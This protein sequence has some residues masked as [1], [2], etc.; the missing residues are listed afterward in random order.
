[1]FLKL[2]QYKHLGNLVQMNECSSITNLF[3]YNLKNCHRNVD[4]EKLH[5]LQVQ[6][7]KLQRQ[8]TLNSN[9]YA[10]SIYLVLYKYQYFLQE[11]ARLSSL[12]NSISLVVFILK[13]LNFKTC[14]LTFYPPKSGELSKNR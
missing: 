11:I 6:L 8:N 13:K 2:Q 12:A 3:V 4:F 9:R 5:Q 7:E 1:M 14:G 10:N